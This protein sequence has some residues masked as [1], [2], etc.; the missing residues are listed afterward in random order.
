MI[1]GIDASRANIRERTGTEQYSFQIIRHLTSIDR[2]HRYVLYVNAA[3]LEELRSLGPHVTVRV[4]NWAPRLLWSQLRLSWE[5]LV[6][7]PDVLFVPAHTI[8]IIHPKRTVTTVH[9]IG[10]ERNVAL[11]G[12]RQIG[13]RGLIGMLL[14]IAVRIVTFGRYS[15]SELDYHRWSARFAASHAS[16]LLTDSEFTK[17]DIIEHYHVDPSHISVVYLGFDASVYRRPSAE[18]TERTLSQHGVTAPYLVFVGRLEK[19]K[20]ILALIEAFDTAKKLIPTLSLVLIGKA[21]LGWE[22]AETYLR[23]HDLERSVNVLGWQPNETAIALIA[24]ATAMV[25]LSEFEGFGLPLLESFAIGTPVIASDRGSIPE[26]GGN[27]ALMVDPHDA[28]SVAR[29]IYSVHTDPSLRN[30]LINLG[31]ERTQKFSWDTAARQTLAVL[32]VHE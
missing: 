19:K 12:N 9:D 28:A 32:M 1:I 20:N 8:P 30:K 25:F 6:H 11:Y 17:R 24:G 22:E 2:D 26:V 23:E 27:A 15:N 7:P 10:F 21:G 5:M 16:H 14:N 29:V 31:R 18:I 13:G 3:P 4:L